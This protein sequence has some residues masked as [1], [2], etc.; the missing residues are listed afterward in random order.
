MAVAVRFQ[1]VGKIKHAFYRMVAIDSRKR[2]DGKPLEVLGHY[3]PSAQDAPKLTVHNDRITYWLQ[4]GARP[5]ETVKSLLKAQRLWDAV[6][7]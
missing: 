2:R 3:N 5:S 1:R 6:R 4:K 7:A